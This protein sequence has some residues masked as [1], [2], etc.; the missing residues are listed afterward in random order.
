MN[1]FVDW[2][3]LGFFSC[4]AIAFVIVAAIYCSASIFAY[5]KNCKS[6]RKILILN[7]LFAWSGVGFFAAWIWAIIGSR[8][9]R[10]ENFQII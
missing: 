9:K 3:I 10:T 7:I 8:E 4:F 5:V 6:K 1:L 2:E